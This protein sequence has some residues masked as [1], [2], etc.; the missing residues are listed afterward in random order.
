MLNAASLRADT[1]VPWHTGARF[2]RMSYGTGTPLAKVRNR[3]ETGCGNATKTMA[4][5]RWLRP[6]ATREIHAQF[7]AAGTFV[8]CQHCFIGGIE[9]STSTGGASSGSASGEAG[10][11]APWQG[12][13]FTVE[14]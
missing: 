13:A 11:Y 12:A 14:Q 1:Y 3:H 10:D 6:N 7:P 4:E 5:N 2:S 8:G 9:F